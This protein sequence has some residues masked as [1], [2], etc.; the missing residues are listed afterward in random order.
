M[1]LSIVILVLLNSIV[2]F[3]T[4]SST[5]ETH[6]VSN[7]IHNEARKFHLKDSR[8]NQYLVVES[9]TLL[10]RTASLAQFEHF[11][12]NVTVSPQSM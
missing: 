8:S 11:I 12:E 2:Q 5:C 6:I 4:A 1:K 7:N 10:L 9:N 3:H